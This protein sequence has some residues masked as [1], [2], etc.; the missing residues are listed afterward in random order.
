MEKYPPLSLSSSRQ[1]SEGESKSGLQ[2]RQKSFGEGM[3][4]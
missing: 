4:G 2:T 1:K 3:A